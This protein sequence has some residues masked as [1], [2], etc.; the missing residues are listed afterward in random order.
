MN[1]CDLQLKPSPYYCRSPYS[2]DHRTDVMVFSV[3]CLSAIANIMFSVLERYKDLR[4]TDGV[5]ES[6]RER[7]GNQ[8]KSL[9][10]LR[11]FRHD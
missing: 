1:A 2:Q 11:H 10:D 8:N 6:Y 5:G 7:E 3:G 4:S 9:L